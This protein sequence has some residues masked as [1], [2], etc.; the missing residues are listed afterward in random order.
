MG[1]LNAHGNKTEFQSKITGTMHTIN[2]T[3][4]SER[5]IDQNDNMT[6]HSFGGIQYRRELDVTVEK[7]NS[8]MV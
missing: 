1:S 5:I 6:S 8:H 7:K 4:S 3:S 2:S